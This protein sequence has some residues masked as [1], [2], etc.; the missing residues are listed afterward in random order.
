MIK[1]D[2]FRQESLL[3]WERLGT[4]GLDYVTIIPASVSLKQ[5]SNTPS[6]EELRVRID[7]TAASDTSESVLLPVLISCFLRLKLIKWKDCSKDPLT[8]FH[9][10]RMSLQNP[11]QSAPGD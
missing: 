10:L 2:I 3:I 5:D 1:A 8:S 6:A 4:S 11:D 9:V 7:Q